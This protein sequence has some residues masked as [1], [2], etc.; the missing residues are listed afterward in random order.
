MKNNCYNNLILSVGIM[1]L[2]AAVFIVVEKICGFG[3]LTIDDRM[4]SFIG[5]LATFVVINNYSQVQDIKNE[6]EMKIQELNNKIG[7]VEAIKVN[8]K[9]S[10]NDINS[11]ENKWEAKTLAIRLLKN[12][13]N[14]FSVITPDPPIGDGKPHDKAKWKL[15]ELDDVVFYDA[16]D[17][18]QK[19]IE[20]IMLVDELEYYKNEVNILVKIYK[21]SYN[22]V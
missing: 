18:N 4:V 16:D 9:I 3:N 11:A 7:I 6:C 22:I 13:N 20:N 14:T 8:G 19:P 15:N 2:C 1:L 21:N 17:T 12:P 10:L 5:I